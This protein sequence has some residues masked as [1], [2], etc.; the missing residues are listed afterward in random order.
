MQRDFGGPRLRSASRSTRG[1]DR[2]E[3][4]VRCVREGAVEETHR[5]RERARLR[6]ASADVG[7]DALS[8]A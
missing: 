1:H 8:L 7:G 4:H 5:D 6:E 2:A 3:V